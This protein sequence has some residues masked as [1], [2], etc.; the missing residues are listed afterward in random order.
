VGFEVGGLLVVLVEGV[1]VYIVES[2]GWVPTMRIV[3]ALVRV[4]VVV[5]VAVWQACF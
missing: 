4:M 3:E 1:I 5:E 2:P